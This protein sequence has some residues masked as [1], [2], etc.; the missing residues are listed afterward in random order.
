MS[1]QS[2]GPIPPRGMISDSFQLEREPHGWTLKIKARD[3]DNDLPD[4][5]C[6]F[7]AWVFLT[8]RLKDA[9]LDVATIAAN[10]PSPTY[11]VGEDGKWTPTDPDLH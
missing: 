6:Y 1:D 10:L 4:P 3:L 7:M 11:E 8:N 9:G 5:L 2:A